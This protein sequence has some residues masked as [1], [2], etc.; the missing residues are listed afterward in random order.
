MPT[1]ETWSDD[2][3]ARRAD[4][5][6]AADRLCAA[7]YDASG[8]PASGCALVAVG[9]YGR[10]ELSPYSDLDV[11][12][13]HEPEVDVRAAG[14]KIWYPVWDSG[15]RL[16]HSVRTVPQMLEQAGAD[17]RVALGLL[18]LRHVAGDQDLSRLLRSEVLGQWRRTAR[19]RMPALRA[20]V[21][22]RHDLV[23]ELARVPVPDL[24]EA[25]GGLRDATVLAALVATW[26]TDVPHADLEGPRLALL[27]VR[28]TL[29]EAAGRATDRVAPG[30]WGGLAERLGLEDEVAA[31]RYVRELGRRITHLS[32]LAWHRADV[33]PTLGGLTG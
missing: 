28:D 16:D 30:S 33:D 14:E 3:V 19:E 1:S 20:L 29:H 23:G 13:V 6:D 25:E 32:W 18:D 26:T 4:R 15:A 2:M 24:K 9:G 10:R 5:A 8:A 21:R 27:D 17:L 7:A 12:L 22:K 11:V 31:Q